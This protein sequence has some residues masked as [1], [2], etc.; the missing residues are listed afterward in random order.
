M[1]NCL[2]ENKI[3]NMFIIQLIIALI[4]NLLILST[5]LKLA[6]DINTDTIEIKNNISINSN[7]LLKSILK[8]LKKN[9]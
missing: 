8:F 4:M 5:N 1:N 7:N 3:K 6:Y 2:C 9:D